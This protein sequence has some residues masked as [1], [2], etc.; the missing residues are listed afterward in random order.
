[1]STGRKKQKK[2][3]IDDIPDHLLAE[4]SAKIGQRQQID[5]NQIEEYNK[6]YRPRKLIEEHQEMKKLGKYA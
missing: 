1:M 4:G 5:D 3:N 6:I 2:G